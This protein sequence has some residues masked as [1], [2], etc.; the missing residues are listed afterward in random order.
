MGAGAAG[1]TIQP[2]DV[3]NG[4]AGTDTFA[5]TVTGDAGGAYTLAGVATNSVE[6]IQISNFEANAGAT[7]IDAALMSGVATVGLYAS[8]ANGDTTIS[9]LQNLAAAEMRNGSGDLTITYTDATVVGTAD[10]QALTVSNI[11][12]GTFTANGTETIVAKTELVKS[13]VT[14]I[15]SDKLKTLTIAGDKDLV[16]SNSID[17]AA[18]ANSTA[19][20][21]TIN[22]S[23]FTG[24]LDVTATTAQTVSITGGS[25]DDTIRMGATLTKD[26][27]VDGGA[28]S[29]TLVIS[30]TANRNFTDNKIS[31]INTLEFGVDTNTLTDVD[32]KALADSVEVKVT[33]ITTD[34]DAT[35]NNVGKGQVVSVLNDSANT[36]EMGDVAVNLEVDTNTDDSVA[37]KL[38]AKTD[39]D[40]TLDLLTIDDAAEA[41]SIN[42]SGATGTGKEYTLTSLIA[43]GAKSIT[44]T[45]AGNFITTL[46]QTG[47]NVTTTVDASAATGTFQITEAV[48][49][50]MTIKGSAGAN[51]FVMAATL[52]NKDTIVGGAS[53]KDVISATVGTATTATTGKFNITGVETLALTSTVNQTATVDLSATTGI[54]KVTVASGDATT[55]AQ[56]L[57]LS[58]VAAGVVIATTEQATNDFDGTI[59]VT[60][61]NAAGTADALTVELKNKTSS[62]NFTLTATDIENLTLAADAA[63]ISADSSVNVSGVNATTITL[64]GGDATSEVNLTEGTTKLNKTVRTVDATAFKGSIVVN[65]SATDSQG[66]TFNMGDLEITDN[67]RDIVTGSAST[68]TDDTLNG[69]L[70]ATDATAEFV[71]R[72]SGIENYNLTLKDGVAIT[73]AANEGLGDGDSAVKTIKLSG[74][75]TLSSYT[76]AGAID[77]A[78]LTSFDASAFN[79][80]TTINVDSSIASK[81][82]LKAGALTT[83]ALTFSAVNGLAAA[84]TGKLTASGFETVALLTATA[85]STIDASGLTGLTTLVVEND[86]NVTVSKLAAGVGIQLGASGSTATGTNNAFTTDDYSGTLTVTLADESG[87]NDSLKVTLASTDSNN[88]INAILVTTAIET[89]E[90]SGSTDTGADDAKLDVSGVKATSL[91]VTGGVAGEVLDLTGTGG[92]K[93]LSS[94]TGTV[95]A[96]A[97]A[98]SLTVIASANKATTITAR[99]NALTFTGSAAADNVTIGAAGSETA[100]TLGAIDG[101]SGSDTLTVFATGVQ[102]TSDASLANIEA[103]ET[104]NLVTKATGADYTI[105]A[106]ASSK[107]GND[108]SA[109][110]ITGGESGKVVTLGGEITDHAFTLDASAMAGSIDATFAAGALV[111]TN[112]ADVISIKGGAGSKDKVTASFTA[113]AAVDTG[114]FSM[115]GVETLAVSSI[116]QGG[117]TGGNTVVNLASVTGLNTLILQTG[118]TNARSVTVSGLKSA[119][120]V[121]LGVAPAAGS[122]FN[123]VTA[124]LDLA[125]ATGTADTLT[126]SAFDTNAGG[127]TATIQTDGVETLTL[128]LN[129]SSEVHKVVLN[130]TNTNSARL[131][132][133]SANASADLTVST[134]A[135]A[136]TTVDASASK[137]AFIMA[138]NSRAGTVA[139]TITTGADDDTIIMKH[140]NDAIDAGANP[141]TSPAGDTL[142]IVQNLVLGGLAIDMTSTTDQIT[143]YNGSANSAVQKGFENV[144]L[145]GIT[146]TFG[147]DITGTDTANSIT[148]TRNADVIRAGKGN[149]VITVATEGAANSDDIDGGEGTTDELILSTGANALTGDATLVNIEKIT[150]GETAS[151]DLTNQTEGF[152]INGG[153]GVNTIEGGAGNDIITAGDGIDAIDLTNGGSDTVK[154][155]ATGAT[156]DDDTSTGFSTGATA[157]GGD[158]LDFSAFLST[159]AVFNTP[160]ATTAIYGSLTAAKTGVAAANKKDALNK[161]VILK[162]TITAYDEAGEIADLFDADAQGDGG[163]LKLSAAGKTVIIIGADTGTELSIAYVNSGADTAVADAE[164]VIVGSFTATTA[165]AVDKFIAANFGL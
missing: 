94:S 18:T 29:N 163:E 142:K 13:T 78:K 80:K 126:V 28:G 84:T 9:N 26:D 120:T 7:T 16:I 47:T 6:N 93:T 44:V 124:K 160:D 56:V 60:L 21:G 98:G 88:N 52:N 134:L 76:A 132:V 2:G 140:A 34:K 89:V 39:A 115:T 90:I 104:I 35:I 143:S 54:T 23:A 108:A 45:G 3:I 5:I 72:L 46:N 156:N 118:N 91:K 122:E 125:D 110:N 165:D 8:S 161:V 24:K 121:Q 135:A 130:N 30:A 27:V 85:A 62:D 99:T 33:A 86:Q 31:N 41:L 151:V 81:V 74:G 48:T 10:S 69:T 105:T 133:T 146:G 65:A 49:N 92:A 75:N 95:D 153:A 137:S 112:V 103:I 141:T 25:G 64:T 96:S 127:S 1:T 101:G 145:S 155:A 37:V 68:T 15:V 148:G 164:V 123:G 82:S 100:A 149:D 42:V 67:S 117:A 152:T 154:F 114:A 102:G 70:A 71:S 111:Q 4:G 12:A 97:F 150:L 32:V 51:T 136:Y 116:S 36:L 73:A 63:G 40:Q 55:G 11:T 53:T 19:V 22:A 58:G 57:N 157:S 129:D 79:G 66:V 20:D 109:L 61:A 131:V 43:D 138:D 147:A 113:N 14:D 107:G 159:V 144:D 139:M 158:V 59:A 17:F 119:T 106:F 87:A 38:I 83:D 162:G 128:A 50:D 77:G